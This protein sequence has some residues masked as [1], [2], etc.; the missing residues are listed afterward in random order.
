MSQSLQHTQQAL[1]Q[2]IATAIEE[3]NGISFAEFMAKALYQP[4]L[5]YYS[6]GLK[7]F[8][9]AGDFITAVELGSL[10][11]ITLADQFSEI[12]Q[13]I[14]NPVVLELGAG[15]GRFCAD[16]LTALSVKDKPEYLPEHYYILEVSADLKQQQQEH[17]AQLPDALKKRVTWLDSPPTENFNGVIFAN[18]V[19]DALPV[20]V[21]Q[22]KNDNFQRLMLKLEDKKLVEYWQAFPDDLQQQLQAKQ[23]TL[24]NGYRSEFIPHLNEWLTTITNSLNKGMVLFIDYG[25]GR[26][27][28]Y[29]P[30]RH[31]GTIVCHQR[32]QANFNPYHDVGAQDITAFVDFTAVAE[33]LK[34]AGCEVVGFNNQAD[35]LLN[36]GIEKNL[37]SDGDYSDYYAQAS[38][39]K[40]LV[41]PTEMGERF[42]CIA[43]VKN[44]DSPLLGFSIN[45]LYDL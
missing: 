10:F 8:G 33:G 38:E 34:A 22:Y 35:L 13:Q 4:G 6:A 26:R 36:L 29:H 17:I 9:K 37:D 11:A 40:Q 25:Y 2:H 43:A 21:F 31:T 20:E 14:D 18:E 5:G 23:L 45:R 28:Y 24:S 16:M 1:W 41:L 39:L 44:I 19:L 27:V 32:H 15:S 7:K 3:N 30:E 12:L 42:K